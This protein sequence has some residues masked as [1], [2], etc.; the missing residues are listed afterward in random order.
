[1]DLS[2]PV[3]S[4]VLWKVTEVL[5]RRRRPGLDL[6]VTTSQHADAPWPS[7]CLV[8]RDTWAPVLVL[9]LGDGSLVT[10]PVA[11]PRASSEL[12]WWRALRY[13]D[14]ALATSPTAVAD[15]LEALVGL[16]PWHGALAPTSPPLLGIRLISGVMQR[17]MFAKEVTEAQCGFVDL[18][19][20]TA[21]VQTWIRRFSSIEAKVQEAGDN[22]RAV[23]RH[24]SRVWRIAGPR[25]ERAVLL[26]LGSGVALTEGSEH[27]R[28]HLYREYQQNGHR[29]APLV[30]WIVE[31]LEA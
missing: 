14:A 24:A 7:L 21:G 30:E 6:S 12:L 31:R 23:A 17:T 9:G 3:R 19:T 28:A 29:L 20:G 27:E 11:E 2:L 25:R 16:P 22:W 26:D 18:G 13:P 5:L 15:E 1:M 10:H 4:V 8:R